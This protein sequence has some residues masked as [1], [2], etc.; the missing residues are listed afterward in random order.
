MKNKKASQKF[1]TLL[2]AYQPKTQLIKVL[3]SLDSSRSYGRLLENK[4]KQKKEGPLGIYICLKVIS[5]I[6][7]Q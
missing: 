3:K 7:P 2:N 6:A 5:E 1:F 4:K